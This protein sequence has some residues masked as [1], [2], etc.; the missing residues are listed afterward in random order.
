VKGRRGEEV[1]GKGRWG[2]EGKGRRGAQPGRVAV[3][4]R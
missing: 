1:K 4:Y 3:T 2:E